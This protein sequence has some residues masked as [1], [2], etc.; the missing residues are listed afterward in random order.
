ME[1]MNTRIIGEGHDPH[2]F[3]GVIFNLPKDK[4]AARLAR[5]VNRVGTMELWEF[6]AFEHHE[7]PSMCGKDA[8]VEEPKLLDEWTKLLSTRFPARQFVI[9]IRPTYAMTWYQR[10]KN[11]PIKDDE[12]F[13]LYMPPYEVSLSQLR[14]LFKDIDGDPAELKSRHRRDFE[15][16]TSRKGAEGACEKCG[17]KDQFS[18][19]FHAENHRGIRL[20]TCLNCNEELIHSFRTVRYLVN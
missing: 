9:E 5:E 7:H 17:T 16:R 15:Q 12:D 6:Q 13:E 3:E 18:E 20:M 14:D 2:E 4:I 8:L 1:T 19:P 10:T 11:A